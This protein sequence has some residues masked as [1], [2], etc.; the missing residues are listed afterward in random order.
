MYTDAPEP[1]FIEAL[2]T[3]VAGSTGTG[4]SHTIDAPTPSL[5]DL[6]QILASSRGV[7]ALSGSGTSG[8]Y[9]GEITVSGGGSIPSQGQLQIKSALNLF[10]AADGTIQGAVLSIPGATE[11]WQQ[12]GGIATNGATILATN[13][14]LI[15]NIDGNIVAQNKGTIRLGNGSGI[16]AEFVD[17]G[18]LTGA[19]LQLK[20]SIAGATNGSQAASLSST[21]DIVLTPNGPFHAIMMNVP[22]GTAVGGNGRGQNSIDLQFTRT[23]ATA[24]ASGFAAVIVGGENNRASGAAGYSTVV[25]GFNNLITG[26]FSSAIGGQNATDDGR[27]SLQVVSNGIL[28]QVGDA[29]SANTVMRGVS[30]GGA[31]VRLTADGAVASAIN[32]FNLPQSKTAAISFRLAARNFT[33]AVHPVAWFNTGLLS[34]DATLASTTIALGTATTLGSDTLTVSVTADTTLGG[35]NFTV[36][37]PNTDTWHFALVINAS[38][39]R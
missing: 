27:T 28:T 22:D 4:I 31:A 14:T 11:Y 7:V 17:P 20:P 8:Q 15:G 1:K 24:V 19:Y 16:L 13:G 39:V 23:L 33:T 36:T 26:P 38:E 29:Q 18:G 34:R 12:Q 37:P 2:Q 35:L 3:V 21:G 30:T 25:G 6:L 5:I 9:D 32:V 10:L